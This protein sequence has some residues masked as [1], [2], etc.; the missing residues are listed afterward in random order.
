MTGQGICKFGFH[1]GAG[2]ALLR[3]RGKAVIRGGDDIAV[4]EESELI[5]SRTDAGKIIVGVA[6]CGERGWPVN[7]WGEHVEAV[8]F[9]VLRAV[10]I[11]R[12]E[13]QNKGSVT[14][15]EH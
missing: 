5:E 14:L 8:A 7:A 15:F 2:L 6:D 1:R 11:A 3:N 12:P 9:I 10:R 13:H 4:I